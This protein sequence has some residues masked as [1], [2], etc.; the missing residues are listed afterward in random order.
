METMVTS[1]DISFDSRESL[2]FGVTLPENGIL[3]ED[4]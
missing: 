2:Y 4:V 3:F 1:L